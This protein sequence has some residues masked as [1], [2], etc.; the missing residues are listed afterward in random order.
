MIWATV[1]GY[2]VFGTFPDG[3][4][5]LGIA[6]LVASGLYLATHLGRAVPPAA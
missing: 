4:T 5:L 2:V 1:A 3:A 6:V